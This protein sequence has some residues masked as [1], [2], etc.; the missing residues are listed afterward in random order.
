MFSS[1]SS[2]Y[3]QVIDFPTT[4]DCLEWYGDTNMY[5]SFYVALPN[6]GATCADTEG[7]VGYW[8]VHLSGWWLAGLP[9]V[10]LCVCLSVGRSVRL[11]GLTVCLPACLPACLPSPCVCVCVC[12]CVCARAC[13]DSVSCVCVCVCVRSCVCACVRVCVRA[14]ARMCVCMCVCA[15]AWTAFPEKILRSA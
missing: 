4:V 7:V 14:R 15:H 12:V 1:W 8:C 6:L 3:L 9:S 13:V 10:C 2:L 5:F 11:V